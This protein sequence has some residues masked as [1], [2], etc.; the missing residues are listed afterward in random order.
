MFRFLSALL[1]FLLSG[2]QPGSPADH[3]LDD[4]LK[5]ISRVTEMETP[6]QAEFTYP[7]LPPLKQRIY[8]IP[9]IRMKALAALN[10][11]ECPRLSKVVA[12]RNS[13]LGRQMLPSQRLHYEKELL[14]ELGDCIH[15]LQET[16][17]KS[18]VLPELKSISEQKQKQLPAIRWNA[19]LG[20]VEL[21]DQLVLRPESL[22][23]EHTGKTGT[24]NALLYLNGY[25]PDQTLSP[26]YSRSEMER[27]LQ[28]LTASHYS[29]QLLR[30]AIK[31]TETLNTVA[32]LLEARLKQRP[33]C[34]NGRLMPA[35]ERLQNVFHLLYASQI[36][37][38]L[39]RIYREGSEW[40]SAMKHL[41]EQL[42]APPSPAMQHYLNQIT[43]D[44]T[45]DSVWY[46]LEQA[47]KRHTS[48]WQ[49]VLSECNLMPAHR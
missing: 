20:N 12:Y 8:D 46:Q 21:S 38:Y 30:S 48:A 27:Q 14:N 11:L 13:S 22:P 45:P 3:L 1:L 6:I 44:N 34:P 2:C 49:A 17:P 10:L 36:Q 23:E 19:L 26:P 32:D 31:L 25:L 18:E 7:V 28:Q 9:D 15:Y 41:L 37:G 35:A 43:S 40:R 24:L 39:S 47:V 5:R 29:G 16:E 42:P 4:Y 33:L